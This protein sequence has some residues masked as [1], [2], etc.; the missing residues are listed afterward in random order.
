MQVV[1]SQPHITNL[2]IYVK[3]YAKKNGQ[4]RLVFATKSQNN[5]FIFLGVKVDFKKKEQISSL[6]I[7][8]Y[9]HKKKYI[10]MVISL[11]FNMLKNR[12][13]IKT[14][15]AKCFIIFLGIINFKEILG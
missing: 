9:I 5:D 13:N 15:K 1:T 3:L 4:N 7:I 2:S 6:F 12:K 11:E 8:I 10:D 14:R